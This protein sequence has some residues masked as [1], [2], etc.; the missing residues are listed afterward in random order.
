MI[1]HWRL[2]KQKY[3]V[4]GSK[5]SCG[6]LYFPVRRVCVKCG[7]KPEDY[8]FSGRGMIESFTIIRVAP[9]G[10]KAPYVVG[11]VKLD[12]G[13]AVAAQI[14]GEEMCVNIGSRVSAVFRKIL[15]TDSSGIICYGFKFEV[16]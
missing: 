6:E 3:S 8:T 7:D 12:E 16:L 14:V 15:E 1:P 11:I 4:V 5:C 2:R 10:F 13:P 9:A